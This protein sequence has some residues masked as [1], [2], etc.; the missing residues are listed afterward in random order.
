M[1][2]SILRAMFWMTALSVLLFWLPVLGPAIAGFVGGRK[3]G[4]VGPAVI[5]AFL[6]GILFGAIL[7]V[8][9]SALTGIPLLGAVAGLG[10]M[11][12]AFAHIGPLLVGAIIGGAVP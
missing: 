3:A 9:A 12:I 10:G 1:E 7:F 11:A 6:P 5:A 8:L 4:G 2:R